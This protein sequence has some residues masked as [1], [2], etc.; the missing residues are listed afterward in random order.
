MWPFLSDA[1]S[2][3]Q[4]VMLLAC[5][6]LALSHILRPAMWIDF[7]TRLHAQG[8]SG[9]VLKV[10]AV[11]LWPGILIVSLHQVWS[12]PGI[13]LTLYGW[14][15]FAKLW[16]TMLAPEI[17]M[18]SMAMAESRGERGF[19]AAGAMLLAVGASAGLALLWG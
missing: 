12:G 8:R 6:P 15:Q 1:P 13:V 4:F 7:F 11:E 3:V 10:L 16:L 17:G 18:R 14:A 5:V 9:L 19:V 2:I